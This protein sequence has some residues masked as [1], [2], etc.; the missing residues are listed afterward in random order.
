MSR[1][2]RPA[3]ARG[4]EKWMRRVAATGALDA[5][6]LKTMKRSG[7]IDWR[8]PRAD[9]AFAEYRD[10]AFLER[11]GL[12]HLLPQLKAFWPRKGPQWDA[13]GLSASGDVLLVEAKAHLREF[14]SEGT[15]ASAASRAK[16]ETALN[17]TARAL[18]AKP[19]GAWTTTFYQLANRL[20]HLWFLREHGVKAWLVLMNFVGDADVGGPESAA[21]WD[22][23]YL[24]AN[25]AMGLPE[26]HAL[27]RYVIH[28]HPDV[29][30][31][32]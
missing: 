10:A 1:Y 26:R 12:S 22:A 2:P 8:S 29:R 6:L 31:F 27:S 23:A 9:D 11:V 30:N 4:S 17:A 21:E 5:A 19:R 28:L 16:I 15:G 25:Y 3:R 24:V 7:A 18:G 14:C 32:G 20:A 13:L